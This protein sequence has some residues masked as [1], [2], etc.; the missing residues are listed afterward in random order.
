MRAVVDDPSSTHEAAIPADHH[1]DSDTDFQARPGDSDADTVPSDREDPFTVPEPGLN[2]TKPARTRFGQIDPTH[3]PLHHH[4]PSF[5]APADPP[6]PPVLH[7]FQRAK[8]P[9]HPA[10][11]PPLKTKA[12]TTPHSTTPCLACAGP[13]APGYCPLKLAGVEYCPLCKMAHYGDGPVCPHLKSETQVRLM[14][15][16]LK[17]SPEGRDVVEQA[18]V[19]LRGRKGHL[20]RVKKE[21]ALKAQQ[22]QGQGQPQSQPQS[23]AHG[24]RRASQVSAASSNSRRASAVPMNGGGGGGERTSGRATPRQSDVVDLT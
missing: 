2:P 14:M 11:N 3:P 16:A 23:K 1:S 13:H 5:P 22:G 8:L 24:S 20:V 17:K 15:E 12:S 9:A 10:G 4:M 21:K 19:Y 7:H 6:H 18:M